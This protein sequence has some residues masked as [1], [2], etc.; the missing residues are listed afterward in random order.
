MV[1][2]RKRAAQTNIF[3]CL[4]KEQMVSEFSLISGR[5]RWGG[6]SDAFC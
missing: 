1:E 5:G 2:R 6:A 4:N 3:L